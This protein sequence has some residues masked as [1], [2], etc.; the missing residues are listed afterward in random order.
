MIHRLLSLLD[1]RRR[2]VVFA[3]RNVFS[4]RNY[5]SD[6]VDRCETYSAIVTV[7]Q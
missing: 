5:V 7:Q 2:V 3:R 1:K 6:I 4:L